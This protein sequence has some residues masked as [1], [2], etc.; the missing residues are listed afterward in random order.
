MTS[1]ARSQ[2]GITLVVALIM[3]ILLTILALSTLSVGRGSLQMTGNAQTQA[4]TESA[5][6]QMIN[7]VISNRVFAETPTNVL[8][9]D[10]CPSSYAAPTNSR[11]VDVNGDGNT[12]VLV[13]LT[14]TPACLQMRPIPT[15]ELNLF[16]AEDLGCTIGLNNQSFGIAGA[17]ALNSLCSNSMWEVTARASDPLTG[18]QA[19]VTQGVTVRV[20]SDSAATSCP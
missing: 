3:L 9:N 20:S 8:L 7:L 1:T 18:A 12:M 17:A 13:Q 11:C 19:S 6:Q 10:N 5:A 14:P 16:V 2:R 4:V 15:S